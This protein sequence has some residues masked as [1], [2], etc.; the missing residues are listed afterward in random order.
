MRDG[1]PV[2]RKIT[3]PGPA[4]LLDAVESPG[5]VITLAARDLTTPGATAACAASVTHMPRTPRGRPHRSGTALVVN[6]D[7]AGN[8]TQR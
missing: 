2:A 4:Q 5:T 7:G 1:R 8:W 6:Q 3:D